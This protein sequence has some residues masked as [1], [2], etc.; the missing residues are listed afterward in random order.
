MAEETKRDGDEASAADGNG[1]VETPEDAEPLLYERVPIGIYI[2]SLQTDA[3]FAARGVSGFVIPLV[4]HVPVNQLE[5]LL[6]DLAD[7]IGDVIQEGSTDRTD[8]ILR[9]EKKFKDAGINDDRL[10]A[11]EA[12]LSFQLLTRAEQIE[13]IKTWRATANSRK[14]IIRKKQNGAKRR[15]GRGTGEKKVLGKGAKKN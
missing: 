7:A 2:K 10:I 6:I 5:G 11:E 15:K 3:I 8:E 4:L 13:K 1:H 9:L 14:S 12:D